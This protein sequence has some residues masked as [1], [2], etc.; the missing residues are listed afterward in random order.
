MTRILT[1]SQ[2][3][4]LNTLIERHMFY[5]LGSFLMGQEEKKDAKVLVKLGLASKGTSVE[6]G[7]YRWY[8]VERW[9]IKETAI[10]R[11][12]NLKTILSESNYEKIFS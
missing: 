1:Q 10:A 7:R 11:N 5:P 6:D 12:I 4:L 8:S 2:K 9:Q 3:Q